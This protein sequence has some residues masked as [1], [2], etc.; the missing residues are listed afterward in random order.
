MVQGKVCKL[1][2]DGGS[3]ANVVSQDF[4]KRM[5]LQVIPHPKPYS[6]RWLNSPDF[7]H[8]HKQAQ[9]TFAIGDYNDT[10]TCEVAPMYCAR[11][12]LG[13]PWHYDR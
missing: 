6:L 11:A 13:R 3:C 5:Q 10:L 7:V 8:I 4:V 2:V 12:L 9:V 1:V